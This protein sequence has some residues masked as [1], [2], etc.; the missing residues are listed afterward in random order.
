MRKFIARLMVAALGAACGVVS[1]LGAGAAYA[2]GAT[3]LGIETYAEMMVDSAHG[4]LFF[5]LGRQ[6]SGVRVTDLSGGAQR[7]IPDL[8]GA[9]GMALSVDGSKLYVALADAGAVA[10]IDTTTLAETQRW[11]IGA[12]SCPTWLTPAGG[13]L[14]LGYGCQSAKG[15]LGSLDL[16]G[17]TPVLALD[18]PLAG[19]YYY[20]P[21][22]RST[23]ASPNLLLLVN[24][25]SVSFPISGEP[26]LY[27]VS[28]G[29]PS[30][31][32]SLAGETCTG[33][34]NAALTAD[35]VILGCSYLWD[36]QTSSRLVATEHVAYSTTDLSPAGTYPSGSWATAVTTSP[37]GAFVVLGASES[38][39]IHV[40]RP[41]GTL[42]RRYVL[43][44]GSHL[45]RQGLAVSADS[46]TLYVVS[47]DPD[48]KNP[49]LRRLSD[50]GTGGTSLLLSAPP[51]STRTAPLTVSGT[52]TFP[53][54][55]GPSTL[56]VVQQ[57]LLGSRPLPEVS[58]AANGTFSFS[59][60]P[61]VGGANTYTVTF[62]GDTTRPGASQSVTVQVSLPGT[63]PTA[64]TTVTP[65]ASVHRSSTGT[66]YLGPTYDNQ[67]ACSSA[68]PGDAALPTDSCGPVDAYGELTATFPTD[69]EATFSAN[70]AGGHREAPAEDPVRTY[71]F[72]VDLGV[73]RGY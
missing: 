10:A 47:T 25:S 66:A 1:P 34:H 68:Q 69:E 28:S 12:G 58:T 22:L 31:V 52:L 19:T 17:A 63:T 23:P 50:F 7:T 55:T 62:P 18:L 38:G 53:D 13:K 21:L 73:F 16:R 33:L 43:P 49:A 32:A 5:S 67:D 3:G 15:K 9:S 56:R 64:R 44:P 8:P 39:T 41:D 37:D 6:R 61:Q 40:E 71:G 57:D 51:T 27:D 46:R 54:G 60:A 4:H 35:R 72:P 70:S 42:V 11:S 24:R 30:Q 65:R 36:P 2:D 48:G 14:Y 26:S 20:P 45:D 59:D 29:T